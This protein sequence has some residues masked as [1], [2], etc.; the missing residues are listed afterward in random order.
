MVGEGVDELKSAEGEGGRHV[1]DPFS[2]KKMP[3]HFG[4]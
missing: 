2:S 3:D 4:P 1:R